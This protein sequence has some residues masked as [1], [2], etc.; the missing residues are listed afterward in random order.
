VP[1]LKDMTGA[2]F[3]GVDLGYR[4]SDYNLAGSHSTYKVALQWNPIESLKVRGSYNRAIRAP[5]INELFLPEQ[6]NFPQ[7]SDPCNFNST[8]RTGPDAAQ[9]AALCQAQ[10]IP[11][12]T[13]PTFT[14]LNPQA[15]S[16]V[17]GN[18]DLEPETADTYTAG[19]AWQSR[20]DSVW[21]SNLSASVDY[22]N[23]E[24]EDVI[25]SFAVSSIIARCFNQLDSNPTYDPNNAFCNLFTRSTANFG[26]QDVLATNQNLGGLKREGVDMQLDYGLPLDAFGADPKWGSL[27]FNV[28]F[29]YLLTAESQE[30]VTSPWFD[31]VGTIGQTVASAFPEIKGRVATSWSVGDF[32]FRYTMRYIDGMDVV[33]NDAILSPSTGA[34]PKVDSYLYHDLSARWNATDMISVTAGITNISDE[35]P[36][37]YTTSAQAGIQSN[38]DPST[39]DVLGLRYFVNVGVKF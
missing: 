6:E 30:T 1:I 35:D 7:Y 21:A 37:I 25:G 2:D 29:T 4:Y 10:G 22:W 3:L 38:T 39:Y 11:A 28:L 34:E 33:N 19:V 16:F 8:F 23:Y 26:V 24:I 13:L 12:A 32:L 27:S 20:A 14:Q 15:R 18:L 31:R 5:S 9:V 17:G 36:P